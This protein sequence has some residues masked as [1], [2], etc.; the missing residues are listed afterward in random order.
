MD[1]YDLYDKEGQ[2]G[3]D[4]LNAYNRLP[5]VLQYFIS[6]EHKILIQ[7]IVNNVRSKYG[8]EGVGDLVKSSGFRAYQTNVR[9]N[10]VSDS[11]HLVGLAADFLKVGIFKDKPIPVCCNLQCI[12]SGK[13]WHIQFRRG[14]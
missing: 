5:T 7:K 3:I 9:H 12:D 2:D 8:E 11:L 14:K 13:C 1:I 4:N 6:S 10:G